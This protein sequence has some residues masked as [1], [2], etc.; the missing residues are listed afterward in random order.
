MKKEFITYSLVFITLI[1]VF[2]TYSVLVC[3]LPTQ[4]IKK[5]I[6]K[7]VPAMVMDDGENYPYAILH[8]QECKMDN[9]T[10][11]IILS[12]NY[13]INNKQP[14]KSAMYGKHAAQY[15]LNIVS[16][17]KRQTDLEDVIIVPYPR[18]WFGNTFLLRPFLLFTN[19]T[20]I[21]WM[22][23]AISSIL[24][25]ILGIKLF[26]LTGMRRTIAFFMG[27]LFVNVFVTQFSIQFF[28]VVALSVIA[29]ILVCNH[30]KNRKKILLL[31]FIIGCFTSY[32]DL[33]TA[34]LLTCGLPL[35]V[36]L[37]AEKEE[38]FKKRLSALFLFSGLWGTGYALTWA[39]KWALGT[40]FTDV[41]VF[42]SAMNT[43]LYR[44]GI[45]TN[46]RLDAVI[47]NINLL[48]LFFIYLF[49]ILL[50]PLVVFFFNKKEIKT[51][52]LLFIVAT[53]PY[54]WYLV[55]AQ[56]SWWH[57]WYTYRIQA[58]SL[59]AIFIIF[60]NFISWDKI[61]TLFRK[62]QKLKSGVAGFLN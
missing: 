45:E 55:L 59:S 10:D 24:F 17:L 58:I 49:F 3:L 39:S 11:A 56:H 1:A 15:D 26:Q 54:L 61:S 31:S 27:L 29:S 9:F 25:F 14:V 18:Y 33:L 43:A 36:Y 7:S 20:V 21:R 5:N 4:P 35:V 37:L 52:L 60:I 44:A 41:N 62:K 57:W 46:S 48:P 40:V 13:T 6:A 23:Y 30:F 34:P 28:S 22:L 32:L 19:Y 8:K 51:N 53:F 50:L 16:A 42:Q 12:Q 38:T 47:S 2:F